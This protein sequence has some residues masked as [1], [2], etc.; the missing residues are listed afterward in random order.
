MEYVV[1]FELIANLV[2]SV[3]LIMAVKHVRAQILPRQKN[4]EKF[5]QIFLTA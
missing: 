2:T 4:I 3:V 1:F 5:K